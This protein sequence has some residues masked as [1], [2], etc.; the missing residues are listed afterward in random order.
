MLLKLLL[1]LSL[2]EH[3]IMVLG[4]RGIS[5]THRHKDRGEL[6]RRC[7]DCFHRDSTCFLVRRMT[8]Y[9]KASLSIGL[10]RWRWASA[11]SSTHDRQD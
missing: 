10:Q 9:I 7:V 2:T 3:P 4:V 1:R 6:L 11:D 8:F 5:W